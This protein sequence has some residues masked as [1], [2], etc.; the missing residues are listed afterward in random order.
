VSTIPTLVF[1]LLILSQ[2]PRNLECEITFAGDSHCE[3]GGN[4]SSHVSRRREDEFRE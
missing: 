3:R 1:S 2:L 4:N